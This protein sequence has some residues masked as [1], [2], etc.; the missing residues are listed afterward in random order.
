MKEVINIELTVI[1]IAIASVVTTVIIVF[2]IKLISKIKD[3]ND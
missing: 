2:G 3:T 1:S